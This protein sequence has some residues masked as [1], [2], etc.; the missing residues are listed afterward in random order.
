[1][2]LRFPDIPRRAAVVA[3]AL[4]LIATIVSGVEG[5][6]SETRT[7]AGPTDLVPSGAAA[8]A[9]PDLDIE[10]LNRA[11]EGRKV[12]DLFAA[13]VIAPPPQA[14]AAVVV[15]PPSPPA[16]PPAPTAPPLPFRYFG[17]WVEGDRTSVFLVGN[18]ESYSASAGDTIA[19]SYRIES[20][21]DSSVD[22]VYLP[23]GSKQALAITAPDQGNP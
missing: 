5:P 13:R 6:S 10:K 22:F 2:K 1:M 3:V 4:A 8:P 15:A 7:A 12:T 23:L 19:G 17:K 16:P 11:R 18:N 9:M 14:A 21:T 20:I